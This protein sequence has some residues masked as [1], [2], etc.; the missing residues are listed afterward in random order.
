MTITELVFPSFKPETAKEALPVF[1]DAAKVFDGVSGL[2]TRNVGHIIRH[3]GEDI[4]QE[5]RS[6]LSI[7]EPLHSLETL[8][9]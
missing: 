5:H 7:G 1:R 3:N 8:E 4:S 2:L 6:V 9:R